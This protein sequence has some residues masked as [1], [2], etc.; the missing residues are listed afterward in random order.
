MVGGYRRASPSIL[1]PFEYTALIAGAIAGYLIWDEVPDRWVLGGALVIIASGLYIVHREV[2]SA[3]SMR[4]LRALTA[5]V[6]ALLSRRRRR[7]QGKLDA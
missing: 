4:Y 2:G 6:S 5:S 3:A 1:A 7:A